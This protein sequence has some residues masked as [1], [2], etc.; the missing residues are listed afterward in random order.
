MLMQRSIKVAE[1]DGFVRRSFPCTTTVAFGRSLFRPGDPARLF[2]PSGK[3][4]PV[5]VDVVRT[6]EDGSIRAAEVTLPVTLPPGGEGVS[7]FEFGDEARPA[8]QLRNPVSVRES[9][10]PVEVVQG[11]VTYRVR[12]QGYNLVDQALFNDRVFHREGGR[13]AVLR[14]RD[15][16]ELLPEGEVRIAVETRGPWSARL[17]VE[18]SYPAGLA[19]LTRMTF[20][21]GKSWFRAEH[22]VTGED[23]SQVEAVALE[24]D[25]C[26]PAGPLTTAFGARTRADGVPTSWAVLTDGA[27]TVDLAAVGAWSERGAVRFEISPD[28]GSRTIFPF[29]GRPCAIYCHY[30]LCPPDDVANTPAAAMAAEP[31]CRVVLK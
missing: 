25:L 10:D 3:E 1:R 16:Q 18:G 21:S 8:A 14:L 27:L 22:Q 17:R 23:L 11:P 30:L 7:R 31:E 28:G 19:F 6:W 29:E 24:V 15:G 9:G 12:R 13:G 20:V 2:D 5:Q 4:Q 26:L